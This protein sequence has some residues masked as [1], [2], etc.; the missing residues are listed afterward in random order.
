MSPGIKGLGVDLDAGIN[1]QWRFESVLCSFLVPYLK[2]QDLWMVNDDL[3]VSSW[4]GAY[5]GHITFP[6]RED[7]RREMWSREDTGVV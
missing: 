6:D 1:Q 7:T 5:I 4:H 3:T 2:I